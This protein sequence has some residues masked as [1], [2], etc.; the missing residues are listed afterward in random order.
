MAFFPH[1]VNSSASFHPLFRLLEDFDKYSNESDKS[2][3]SHHGP[4]RRSNSTAMSWQPRFDVRETDSAY[5]LHG[6]LPGLAKEN[7][8]IEFSEPQTIIIRGRT[9]RNYITTSAPAD[10]S[11]QPAAI[12]ERRNSHQATVEDAPEAEG[13]TTDLSVAS[14]PAAAKEQPADKAKYWLSERSIGEFARTFQFPTRVDQ[15]N[16]SAGLKDGI[17]SIVVPKAKKYESR[18]ITIN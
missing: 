3:T 16:V 12:E 2:H 6:E 10:G 9:E 1:A 7:V 5:E 11:A 18:S 13:K 14:K 15:D 4:S 17:L 8:A